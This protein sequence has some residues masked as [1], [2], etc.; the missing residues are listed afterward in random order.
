MQIYWGEYSDMQS[1]TFEAK[2]V[3]SIVR[4]R[5]YVKMEISSRSFRSVA[6]I[7]EFFMFQVKSS[8]FLL[9]KAPNS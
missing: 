3:A 2:V 4:E 7:Y 6:Q 8:V 1:N 9:F 5:E